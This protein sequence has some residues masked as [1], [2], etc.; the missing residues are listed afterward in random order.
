M[1]DVYKSE[2]WAKRVDEFNNVS[3]GK[4]LLDL[5]K[6]EINFSVLSKIR[7]VFD[8]VLWE[9]PFHLPLVKTGRRI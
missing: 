2:S 7:A 6:R 3:I 5:V 8:K 1:T 4:K 9:T